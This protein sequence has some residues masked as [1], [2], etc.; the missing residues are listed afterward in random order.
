[1]DRRVGLIGAPTSV[2]A[3]APGQEKAPAAFRRHGL[4]AALEA[5][6]IPI[7]DFGDVEGL[8]WRPDPAQRTAA[9]LRS[10]R[11]TCLAVADRVEQAL[12][13]GACGLVLGGDCTIELG[14]VAG[15]LRSAASVGLIY[16]DRDADLNPPGDSD[17]A[18]DWTG[19]AHL[20]AIE[21]AAAE[22]ADL[23]PRRPMLSPENVLYFGLDNL[24]RRE[25]QTMEALG[26]VAIRRAEV[27]ADPAGAARRALDW[28]RGYDRLLV[29]LDVD[30]LDFVDFPIAE[31]VRREPG[32][33]FAALSVALGM[34]AQAH[35]LS[36]V[37]VTEVNPDHAPDEAETFARFNRMLAG[38]LGGV[39]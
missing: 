19:V 23:G 31:N 37:T 32:I 2:G 35:N 11:Q 3:Y 5:A 18:L 38:A 12:A 27:E 36:A 1:M 39:S 13:V 15:S 33:S 28:A 24:E 9:N 20:L 6:G 17:G 30:V 29:H 26:L 14:V 7:L 16:I 21:G 22:L 34:L 8:R 25:P 4:V 10:V